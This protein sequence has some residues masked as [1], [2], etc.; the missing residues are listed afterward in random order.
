M[1]ALGLRWTASHAV[2]RGSPV[3]ASARRAEMQHTV[4]EAASLERRAGKSTFSIPESRRARPAAAADGPCYYS[5]YVEEVLSVILLCRFEELARLLTSAHITFG[6]ESNTYYLETSLGWFGTCRRCVSPVRASL[7][8]APSTD[9][10]CG[11]VCYPSR[12]VIRLRSSSPTTP[13]ESPL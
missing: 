7:H 8:Q 9:A 1:T 5:R 3:P 2:L 4:A 10:I 11:D 13:N 6:D 12:V